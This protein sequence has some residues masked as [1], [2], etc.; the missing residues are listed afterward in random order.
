MAGDATPFGHK[1]PR[2]RVCNCR[3]GLQT[4]ARGRGGR[5]GHVLCQTSGLGLKEP[6]D[7]PYAEL[8]YCFSLAEN[9]LTT[10]LA[11][12]LMF[13]PQPRIMGPSFSVALR[14]FDG[15]GYLHLHAKEQR[16]RRGAPR[17]ALCG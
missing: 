8:F 6:P 11:L 5:F 7:E 15:L 3:R 17:V 13:R 10:N 14:L 1:Y 2:R 12:C 9:N 16:R 4:D